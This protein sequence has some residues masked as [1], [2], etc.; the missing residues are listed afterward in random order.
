MPWLEGIEGDGPN[1]QNTHR[2][3]WPSTDSLLN[4]GEIGGFNSF[5]HPV[6]TIL[7]PGLLESLPNVKIATCGS[8]I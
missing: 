7:P 5:S 8:G 2:C 1:L 4:L 6:R 3:Y